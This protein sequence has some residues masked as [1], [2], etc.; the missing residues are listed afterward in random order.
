MP[1]V[2][3]LGYN[4]T[5]SVVHSSELGG[6]LLAKLASGSFSL[7]S[8]EEMEKDREKWRLFREKSWT[9]YPERGQ[10]FAPLNLTYYDMLRADL[11]WPRLL[12]G[13]NPLKNLL[14]PITTREV[15]EP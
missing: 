8:K 10:C 6:K 3:F 13:S 15:C 7:P 9:M 11:G 12:A 1:S 14:V 2:A 4:M 5:F